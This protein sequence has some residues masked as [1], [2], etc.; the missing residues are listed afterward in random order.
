MPM[1]R[2]R[3]QGREVGLQGLGIVVHGEQE[4]EMVSH[5]FH[6]RKKAEHGS[7]IFR[8]EHDGFHGFGQER[9]ARNLPGVEGVG[10]QAVSLLQPVHEPFGIEGGYVGAAAGADDHFLPLGRSDVSWNGRI[11]KRKSSQRQTYFR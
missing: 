8:P 2:L 3:A 10:R 5:V 4:I 1:S 7:W 9:D 6:F 11:S